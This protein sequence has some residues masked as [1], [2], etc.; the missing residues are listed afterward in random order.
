MASCNRLANAALIGTKLALAA[1]E[2]WEGTQNVS[3]A[4]DAYNEGDY[5]GAAY[6][7]VLASL[8]V[9][10]VKDVMKFPAPQCFPAGTLISTET[11][12][13]PIEEIH[14]GETV[15]AFDLTTNTWHLRPVLETYQFDDIDEIVEITANDE[16]IKSTKGHPFWVIEG[17]DLDK[18]PWPV[19]IVG[20]IVPD[21][22]VPGRWVDAGDLKVGDVLLLKDRKPT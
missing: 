6:H 21:S 7:T 2:I 20:A 3:A 11:G 13:K 1:R 19:H 5:V 15:W 22:I 14:P 12:L 10:G 8:N 16:V 17:E 9:L 18:R 4:S